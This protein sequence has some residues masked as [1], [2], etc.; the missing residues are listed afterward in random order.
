MK[1]TRR[2]VVFDP[3]GCVASALGTASFWLA[4]CCVATAPWAHLR[5][6]RCIVAVARRPRKRIPSHAARRRR[7]LRRFD[8]PHTRRPKSAGLQR[9]FTHHACDDLQ[10]RRRRVAR[11]SRR[12]NEH[13]S[14]FNGL[15]PHH[16]RRSAPNGSPICCRSE[17][18]VRSTA[19]PVAASIIGLLDPSKSPGFASRVAHGSSLAA[20][21]ARGP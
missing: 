2:A 1:R 8:S 4:S 5:V 9:Q 21:V 13:R 10:P 15:V 6:V 14:S 20:C 17:R 7:M 16:A 3:G 18:V 12:A 19:P 11:H